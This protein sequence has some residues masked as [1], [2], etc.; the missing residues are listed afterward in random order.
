MSYSVSVTLVLGSSQ[1]SLTLVA[2]LFD[3]NGLDVN[4]PIITGFAEIGSGNYLWTG[5][6]PD[7]F[8]GGIKIYRSGSP[9]DIL[10]IVA[11][12][13]EEIELPLRTSELVESIHSSTSDPKEI[14]IEVP[15]I[16]VNQ[17]SIDVVSSVSSS[18]SE[19]QIKTGVR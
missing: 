16:S 11:I 6:I 2:Q 10:A 15:H 13:P 9:L 7:N 14:T 18:N 3:T 19:I 12:N 1:T 8:R 5:E 17:S 4:S